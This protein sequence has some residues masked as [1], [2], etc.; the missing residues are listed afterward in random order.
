MFHKMPA[1]YLSECAQT[2]TLC[3]LYC[4]CTTTLDQL[5]FGNDTEQVVLHTQ[6]SRI[7]INALADAT[8]HASCDYFK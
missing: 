3:T 2:H 8:S 7:Y 6:T 5:F 4:A 1:V